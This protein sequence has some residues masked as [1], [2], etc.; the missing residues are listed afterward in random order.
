MLILGDCL[1]V[2]PTLPAASV[3]LILCDLPYGTTACSWD[4]IIPFKPLWVQYRRVL[5]PGG[6]TVLTAAQ[7][8]TSALVL[9]QV[10]FFFFF[11]FFFFF[12]ST[13]WFGRKVAFS[14]LRRHRTVF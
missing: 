11:F 12:L 9:S 13:L 1:E 6:A 2:M 14:T 10:D 3:D 8:F 4:A 5:R 7:P